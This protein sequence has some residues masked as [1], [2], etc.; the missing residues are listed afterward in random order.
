VHAGGGKDFELI[1]KEHNENHRE[2]E[3]RH[4][5]D[6]HGDEARAPVER[7]SGFLGLL[8]AE[9]DADHDLNRGCERKKNEGARKCLADNREHLTFTSG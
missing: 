6:N 7:A 1:H 8:E 4:A 2:P 9:D 3:C 5:I